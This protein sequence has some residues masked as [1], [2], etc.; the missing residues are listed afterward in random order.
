MLNN[1]TITEL[2][3]SLI[4]EKRLIS[5]IDALYIEL[6]KLDAESFFSISDLHSEMD[7]FEGYMRE[8]GVLGDVP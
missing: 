7:K 5:E 2:N 4:E 1:N 6:M 8:Q 3:R